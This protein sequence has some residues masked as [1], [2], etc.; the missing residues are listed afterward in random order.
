MIE[1][2]VGSLRFANSSMK[3]SLFPIGLNASTEYKAENGLKEPIIQVYAEDMNVPS[4][5]SSS[6]M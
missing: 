2:A 6:T 1:I 3:F 4:K 5:C